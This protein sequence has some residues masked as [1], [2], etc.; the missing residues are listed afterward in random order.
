MS[1]VLDASMALSWCF[2]DEASDLGQAVLDA[3]PRSVAFVP[4]L[5]AY[6]TTNCLWVAKCRDRLSQADVDG[7]AQALAALPI[8]RVA[9]ETPRLFSEVLECSDDLSVT[10]YDASYLTMAK[11]LTLPLATLDSR[12]SAAAKSLGVEV[13]TTEMAARWR[14]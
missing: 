7:L 13:V 2:A 3:L 11:R 14:E 1:F 10:V 6:E 8:V 9:I 4:D 12:M 5:W